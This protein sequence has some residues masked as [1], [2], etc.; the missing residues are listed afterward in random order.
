MDG[1]FD[2]YLMGHLDFMGPDPYEAATADDRPAMPQRARPQAPTQAHALAVKALAEK[3]LAEAKEAEKAEAARAAEK[4]AEKAAE[5]EAARAKASE[6]V[7]VAARA[8]PAPARGAFAGFAPIKN[9]VIIFVLFMF[10]SS[11]FF[12][13]SVLSGSALAGRIPTTSGVVIQGIALV[14]VFALFSH[15]SDKDII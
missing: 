13:D 14:V 5:K 6:T 9:Y 3:A 2:E 15:L 10:V 11:D 8:A 1:S 12:V 4:E 7:D